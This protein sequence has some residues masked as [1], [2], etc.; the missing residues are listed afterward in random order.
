MG[1]EK[2]TMKSNLGHLMDKA[3][4]RSGS[5]IRARVASRQRGVISLEATVVMAILLFALVGV[6]TWLK[7]NA[8]RQQDQNAADNLNTVFKQGLTW[9]NANYSTVQAAAAPSVTYPWATFMGGTT[10]VSQT[11]VY[12]QAYSMRV[13][14]EASGQLDMM[15]VTT[16]GEDISES[17]VQRVAKMVGGAGGYV[18]NLTPANATGA[19]G[20]W[21]VPMTNFGGTPG[22]G[23]IAAAAFFANA[24][25]VSNYLSRVV[26]PGNP[27]ANQMETNIDMNDNNLNNANQVKA[28]QVITPAGNGVQVGSSFYYGDGANSAIRQSGALYIQNQA[29]SGA[30]DIAE[31]GNV[32]AGGQVTA[33]TVVSNGNI[34]AS[35]GTVT[36]AAMHSTGN[37]QVDGSSNVNGNINAGGQITSGG[38]FLVNGGAAQ[39]GAC[40]GPGY[41]GQGPSGP[42]MCQAG[43]WQSAGAVPQGTLCGSV[44]AI[45]TGGPLGVPEPDGAT[46]ENTCQGMAFWNNGVCPTGYVYTTVFASSAVWFF[47]CVKT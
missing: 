7:T 4:R 40:P 38:Y 19:M 25:A 43:T 16:G 22:P 41:I 21:T 47:S 17:S 11:N 26:V 46:T 15:I 5:R 20:G 1:I 29:G 35:N 6:G 24:A 12:G 28:N 34:W 3:G 9:F 42:L 37:E 10:T 13:N 33:G 30:A 45:A 36:A 27:A 23:H 18:S 31:V 39:G 14:K 8:D 32:T 44:S 2:G